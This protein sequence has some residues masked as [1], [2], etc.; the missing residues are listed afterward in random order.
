MRIAGGPA[1]AGVV[2]PRDH[3]AGL[4]RRTFDGGKTAGLLLVLTG[5]VAVTGV[6]VGNSLSGIGGGLGY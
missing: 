1:G 2:I 3:A 6:I 4:Q 5:I